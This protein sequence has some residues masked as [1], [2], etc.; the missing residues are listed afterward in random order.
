MTTGKTKGEEI[1]L[2]RGYTRL[3][4]VGGERR[5]SNTFSLW[6]HFTRPGR[7]LI[8]REYGEAH[9]GW[10]FYIPLDDSNLV[11]RTVD[12]LDAWEHGRMQ[13]DAHHRHRRT[14]VLP[15]ALGPEGDP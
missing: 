14:T 7:I 9:G 10:D 3:V 8:L 2:Q 1:L 6:E 11:S 15:R 4:I 5:T 12:A 13:S